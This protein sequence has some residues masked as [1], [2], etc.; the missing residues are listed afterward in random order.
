MM[1][2][3]AEYS[4]KN[5]FSTIKVFIWK[6]LQ[7]M[8]PV[9]FVISLVLYLSADWMAIHYFHKEYLGTYLKINA[10]ITF[11]LVLLL[12]HSESTRGLKNIL[13]ILFIKRARFHLLHRTVGHCR[14]HQKCSQRNSCR[15]PVRQYFHR[16][17]NEPDVVVESKPFCIQQNRTWCSKVWLVENCFMPMFTTTVLQL[18]MSWAG[19]L[20]LAA[21]ATESQVGDL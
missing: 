10:W 7:L 11:P 19:T 1:K 3:V 16:R 13:L 21:Y 5:D 9:T 18:I 4:W 17:N 2:L 20:I 12:F 8:L 14:V 6:A 15:D